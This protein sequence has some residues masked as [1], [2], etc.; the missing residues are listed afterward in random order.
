MLEGVYLHEMVYDQNR[1]AIDYRILEANPSS[2]EHLGINPQYANGKL[3]TELYGTSAPPFFDIYSKVTETGETV[4]FEHYFEPMD[5]WF[6]ISV[7]RLEKGKFVTIF[8]DI[9]ERIKTEQILRQ[10]K[11]RA[12]ES[13]LKFRTI[14][15]TIPDLVWLKDVNGVYLSCNKRFE[16][17]YGSPEEK[18]IGKTDYDFV[19]KQLADFFR[20]NDN[21]ALKADAPK[22][23]EEKL[24][25]LSDGHEEYCE[26]IKT[27]M[28]GLNNQLIGILGIARNITERKRFEDELVKAKEQA[29][30]A[31]KSK[32]M[33][34]ANMSHE[35]RTPMNG[36]M[37]FADLLNDG[38]ITP[39]QRENFTKIIRNSGKH[40]LTI[41]D[42]IL[43]ISRLETK[44]VKAVFGNVCLNELLTELYSIFKIDEKTKPVPLYLK[45]VLSDEE[46]IVY[47]DRTKLI[48]ILSNLLENA[49]RYTEI[50]FIELGYYVENNVITIYVKDT[51]I[52]IEAENQTLVF[53]RFMQGEVELSK[54]A[55][56]L[57]LGLSIVKENAELIGGKINVES[58]VGKGSTFSIT[59]P[60]PKKQGDKNDDETVENKLIGINKI[61]RLLITEDEEINF[62]YLETLLKK[63]PVKFEVLHAQNGVQAIE[64]VEKNPDID[65]ILM[66]LKMPIMD[67]YEATR[68]IKKMRPHIPIVA[69]TAYS[70]IEEKER[71][72]EAGCDDF[73][74]KP[75]SR[76]LFEQKL[77]KYFPVRK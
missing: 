35:I 29:E 25:F 50:G 65:L 4:Q 42:D 69:Q 7:F 22:K 10:S 43:E 20:M 12:E 26:T 64:T 45:T 34:L 11:E 30:R 3:A 36:I 27:P 37:G 74:S 63:M 19:D 67:G 75:I 16:S 46:S 31:D 13:E 18:I 24:R 2:E 77:I 49:F 40:L 52:G 51:G 21:I 39:K 28:Y 44:R 71:A 17:L 72:I 55:G 53:E 62:L 33:F 68:Q 8:S 38:N 76:E 70:T 58:E 23:N 15:N 73:I 61:A 48:K 5:K 9:S 66:D 59:I 60:F 54:K 32:S 57:G 14:I 47:T 1:L 41:I 6:K 56:G